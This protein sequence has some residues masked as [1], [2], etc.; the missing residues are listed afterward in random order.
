MKITSFITVLVLKSNEQKWIFDISGCHSL[1]T[2]HPYSNFYR[3]GGVKKCER[4][5]R[6]L[7]PV[8]FDALWLPNRAKYMKCK[9]STL[10]ADDRLRS[11]PDT[12][13]IPPSIFTGRA[14]NISKFGLIL[15]FE[16]V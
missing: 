11:D 7:T 1:L 4:W 8:A 12:S 5:P 6:F 2:V 15:A 13:P 3:G 14:S 10:S 16:A 9:T